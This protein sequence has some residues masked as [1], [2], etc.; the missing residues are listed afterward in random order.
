MLC[1]C[2]ATGFRSYMSFD[3]RVLVFKVRASICIRG[4]GR[5]S[6]FYMAANIQATK[7]QSTRVCFR[8]HMSHG[9]VTRRI[10]CGVLP[11]FPVGQIH[12]F[13][14]KCIDNTMKSSYE[15][16]AK[17]IDQASWQFFRK[18]NHVLRNRYICNGTSTILGSPSVPYSCIGGVGGQ[19]GPN[20]NHIS[21]V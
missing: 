2:D 4:Q 19:R 15:W 7:Q 8:P 11:A 1:L 5:T 13:Y 12:V 20:P 21:L 6:Y 3:S 9:R 14:G 17:L 10:A 16:T 18:C